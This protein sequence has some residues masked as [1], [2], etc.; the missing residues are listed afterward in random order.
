MRAHFHRPTPVRILLSLLLCLSFLL[1]GCGS[2][3]SHVEEPTTATTEADI[4][5]IAPKRP[6]VALTFDDGPHNVRTADI[7][8]ELAKYNYHATFFVI[9][10]R[11][12]GGEYNGA[13]TI[14]LIIGGGHEIGIH[15]YTHSKY[16]DTCS[17]ADYGAEIAN[18]LAAIHE[19]APDYQ[20]KLMRPVGGR[21]SPERVLSSPYSV[22]LWSVDSEDWSYKYTSSDTD[23]SAAEK[24][25]TIVENVMSSVSDGDIILMHDIYES[26]YDAVVILL[27]RLHAAGYDVVTVSEL[28]G[29]ELVPG[30]KYSAGQPIIY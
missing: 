13:K 10:D 16:Y 29:E 17:D 26:T 4:S 28:L 11:I 12:D 18:T 25:N 22:I 14:P 1:S 23:E 2:A 8:A 3:V 19:V 9:G 6:R 7:L 30:Q 27:A 24:V 21:M 20:V 5:A 15:G